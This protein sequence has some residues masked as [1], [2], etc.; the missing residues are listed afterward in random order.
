M[1][2]REP[3]NYVASG[4]AGSADGHYLSLSRHQI[5]APEGRTLAALLTHAWFSTALD[6]EKPGKL[7]NL[8]EVLFI[9]AAA[10]PGARITAFNAAT[11]FCLS[12]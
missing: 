2:S 10:H 5:F 1:I 6:Q 8:N 4:G 12:I 9:Q 3:H 7:R 11:S